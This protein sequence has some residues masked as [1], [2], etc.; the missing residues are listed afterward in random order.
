MSD[1]SYVSMCH[2]NDWCINRLCQRADTRLTWCRPAPK[3]LSGGLQHST[4]SIR[5]PRHS[6]VHADL[7]IEGN[8]FD[9]GPGPSFWLMDIHNVMI[10]GNTISYCSKAVVYPGGPEEKRSNYAL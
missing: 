2:T 5:M 10:T 3:H 7:R 1:L 4:N 6:H 8:L 9:A